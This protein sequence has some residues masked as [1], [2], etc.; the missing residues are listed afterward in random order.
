MA[1]VA[2][3][4]SDED[5]K[6]LQAH[7]DAL[8]I[9]AEAMATEVVMDLL[10]GSDPLLGFNSQAEYEAFVQEGIDSADRGELLDWEDVKADLR[11]MMVRRLA[12]AGQ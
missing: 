5:L 6:R 10:H 7:A 11:A 3:Q 1:Q 4:L 2:I 8:D 9:S 12:E